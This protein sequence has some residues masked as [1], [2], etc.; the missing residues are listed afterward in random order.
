MNDLYVVVS[1]YDSETCTVVINNEYYVY[2]G[3]MPGF[4][5]AEKVRGIAKHSPGKA[6]QWIK[7]NAE[8]IEHYNNKTLYGEE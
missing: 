4:V 3:V 6:I 2:K 5:L 1:A 8:M 7:S